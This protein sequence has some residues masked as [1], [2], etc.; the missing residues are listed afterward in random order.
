MELYPA[1][2]LVIQLPTLQ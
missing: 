1:G 2:E